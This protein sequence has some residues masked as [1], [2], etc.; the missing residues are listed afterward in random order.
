MKKFR[1]TASWMVSGNVDV[2]ADTME[3]AMAKA[4]EADLDKFMCTT[5]IDDSYESYTGV[6]LDENGDEIIDT[7]Q[8]LS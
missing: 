6:E 2:E 3:A 8:E 1:I 4:Y 5:Y 7:M